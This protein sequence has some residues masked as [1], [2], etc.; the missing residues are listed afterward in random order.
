MT[1]IQCPLRLDSKLEASLDYKERLLSLKNKN[2]KERKK[3]RKKEGRRKEERKK[4]K[5]RKARCGVAHL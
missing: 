3:E 5:G 2:K 1:A 4:R